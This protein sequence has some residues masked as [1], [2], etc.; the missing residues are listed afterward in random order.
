MQQKAYFKIE[1]SY[2]YEMI[3]TDIKE[4][5]SEGVDVVNPLADTTFSLNMGANPIT[6]SI[7]GYLY[8]SEGYNQRDDFT[9]YYDTKLR[10]TKGLKIMFGFNDTI[11][12]LKVHSLRIG[13]SSRLQGAVNLSIE[14]VGYKY[15]ALHG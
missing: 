5:H 15:N 10:G 6:V 11:F 7:T 13:E 9:Q 14:G 3:I 4:N 1:D 12:N 8:I 2:Y